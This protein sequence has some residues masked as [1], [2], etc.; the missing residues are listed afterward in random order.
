VTEQAIAI[1]GA[2]A[3]IGGLWTTYLS[4][5]ISALD[6]LI[7]QLQEEVSRLRESLRQAEEESAQLRREMNALEVRL[8]RL[9]IGVGRL[10]QQIKDLG[11][12]PVWHPKEETHE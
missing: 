5:R 10:I 9:Q 8:S 11:H 4:S 3:A 6:G 2:V 7:D 12:E 1:V